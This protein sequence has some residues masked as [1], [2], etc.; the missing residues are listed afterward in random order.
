ME[1]ENVIVFNTD[2]KLSPECGNDLLQSRNNVSS[3]LYGENE[4][5]IFILAYNNLEKTE[6]CVKYYLEHAS[7]IEHQ[8]ILFDNGSTEAIMDLFQSIQHP[9]KVIY[10][11]TKNIGV[12]FAMKKLFEL[13]NCKYLIGIQNDVYITKNSLDNM[14]A[15][16]KSDEKIAYVSC[17][18]DN[19]SN[20]QD[21]G[22]KFDS[23]DEMQELAAKFNEKS[24]P[25]KW[26]Q[27]I[28]AFGCCY[29]YRKSIF[30]LIGTF[31]YGF[32]HDFADDD[33][34][35]RLHR[36]G[37]KQY[38]CGDTF[39]HHNHYHSV[40]NDQN[41]HANSLDTGRQNFKDKF[42]QLDAWVDVINYDFNSLQR[43]EYNIDNANVLGVDPLCGIPLYE[44]RNR[45]RENGY[46]NTN[47]YAFTT[48]AKHFHDLQF[49]TEN[50]VYC[51]RIN[52]INDYY[53]K[54][55]FDTIYLGN[56]IN[57]YTEPLKLL[58][59]LIELLVPGGQ[60]LIKLKN[61]FDINTICGMFG[62]NASFNTEFYSHMLKDDILKFSSQLGVAKID[63]MG[64]LYDDNK[65]FNELLNK[66][67]NSS[68][69]KDVAKINK[70]KI[71]EYCFQIIR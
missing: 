35:L 30:D 3:A 69:I 17:M 44:I 31:D 10:K 68:V 19:V 7:H 6:N 40:E 28:R 52:F 22:L 26:Q 59:N 38:I 5:C 48:D 24:D 62:Q 37:Y 12:S 42:N 8:L 47:L 18:Q 4:I 66:I 32:F 29:I 70:L 57:S 46:Y 65:N 16:I 1:Y 25:N 63:T 51:D 2:D 27:K 56:Y 53:P 54:N 39:I 36:S 15:C 33:F 50:K 49:T 41:K 9:N 11:V 23:L 34:C 61:T 71:N 20:G 45:F 21:P 60:L 58:E 64:I 55:V 14:L 13:S 43:G 67:L